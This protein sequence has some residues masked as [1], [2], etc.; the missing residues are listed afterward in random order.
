MVR[1][2]FEN[3]HSS[4]GFVARNAI[5]NFHRQVQI[6]SS[7]KPYLQWIEDF[8]ENIINRD[9]LDIVDGID[10]ISGLL[11]VVKGFVETSI[12][13]WSKNHM[14]RFV[15]YYLAIKVYNRQK[16]LLEENDV[17]L[18]SSE[19]LIYLEMMPCIIM[20]LRTSHYEEFA[21]L[22]VRSEIV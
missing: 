13:I 17:F 8:V 16:R 22:N 10:D 6:V 21:I 2:V 3:N 9:D 18:L 11:A 5:T 20:S 4:L 14:V 19:V 7:C 15:H 1:L 12:S